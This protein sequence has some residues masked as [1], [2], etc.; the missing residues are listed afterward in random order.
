M[1][2]SHRQKPGSIKKKPSEYFFC[3]KR[4]EF[5]EFL[6]ED[7]VKSED[8]LY[9][10]EQYQLETINSFYQNRRSKK[11]LHTLYSINVDIDGIKNS[12]PLSHQD[13]LERTRELGFCDYPTEIVKTSEGRFHVKFRIEPARAFPDKISYWKKCAE[14]LYSAFKDL[15]ADKQATTNIIGFN[16]LPGHVNGKYSYKPIVELVYQSDV[17]FT[18]A[19]I[20]EVLRDNGYVKSNIHSKKTYEEKIQILLNLDICEGKRNNAAFT[21]ALHF[22]SIGYKQYDTFNQL[23]KWS[24]NLSSPLYSKELHGC[25]KSAYNP[26]YTRPSFKILNRLIEENKYPSHK[27]KYLSI[28][29]PVRKPLTKHAETLRE[30]IIKNGGQIISSQR[31]LAEQLQIP[32]SSF[33]EAKKLISDIQTIQLGKGRNSKSRISIVSESKLKLV[34]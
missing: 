30:H 7:Y 25:C 12:F 10:R 15:G 23:I 4:D 19:D 29:E 6:F 31:K 28:K 20:Y 33:V 14:G 16:R 13:I 18:L 3:Q 24:N 34:Q 11:T 9:A 17:I 2:M 22:K 5:D 21:I 32:W 27:R 26:K 8:I 1:T